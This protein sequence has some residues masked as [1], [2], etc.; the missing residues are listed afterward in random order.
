MDAPL[1]ARAADALLLDWRHCRLE[2]AEYAALLRDPVRRFDPQQLET[3]KAFGA[4]FESESRRLFDFNSGI[5]RIPVR[6]ALFNDEFIDPFFGMSGYKGLSTQFAAA[7]ADSEVRA[8]LFDINSP[9][10]DASGVFDLADEIAAARGQG[11]RIVAVANDMALSAAYAIA[12]AADMIFLPR[13]G[14][15][16]SIGVWTMHVDIS[17]AL[18][19]MGVEVTLIFAG[20]R[21]I[22]GHPFGP[23]PDA[24]KE[25]IQARIDRTHSLFIDTVAANRNLDANAVRA[26]EA[27]SFEDSDGIAAGLADGI[28]TDKEVAAAMIEELAGD[29]APTAA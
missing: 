24:V 5:A 15:V 2:P 11:K 3:L 10:G 22:D 4:S 1:A 20:A 6:G 23:L 19:K 28:A 21:K 8:I 18:E 17:E 16:G 13:L 14:F 25:R 29:P 26:T 9:G 7:M 27:E 12:S